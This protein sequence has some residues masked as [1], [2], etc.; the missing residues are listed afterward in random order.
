MQQII[1]NKDT[2][3]AAADKRWQSWRRWVAGRLSDTLAERQSMRPLISMNGRSPRLA[4]R[5]PRPLCSLTQQEPKCLQ[6]QN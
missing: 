3:C 1:F 6:T 4:N 2:D 5:A